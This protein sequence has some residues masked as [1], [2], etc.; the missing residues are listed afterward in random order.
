MPE[1]PLHSTNALKNVT[2]LVTR[3]AHQAD[4]LACLIE[5]QG[6]KAV[7]FPVIEILEPENS[8]ALR[9]I[10]DHLDQF[11]M[12][13]FISPN[14]VN[15]A[16][17]LIHARR[18]GLP[19]ELRIA[20]VGRVSANELMKYGISSVIAPE[21]K[22]NSEALLALPE[23]QQVEKKN[24]VIFRGDGGRGLLGDTLS[25]RGADIVYAECY[26]RG[27]PST[28]PM[29]LLHS[30]S[31][32]DIGIVTITSTQGL[33]NLYSM[34]GTKGRPRLLKTPVIVV[35]QKQAAVCRELGFK[36]SPMVADEPSDEAIVQAI[37]AWRKS[38]HHPIDME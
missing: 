15:K 34:V 8:D 28:N 36:H 26:R 33:Q 21:R 17:N 6:G 3:P 29:P 10:V 13:I 32:G 23:L 22:F 2:V 11:D 37:K 31:G 30:W 5:Q 7:R 16:M 9:G 12:A 27:R 24:I 14:A 25:R 19:P 4:N 20:C 18:G 35:S 38:E 1:M